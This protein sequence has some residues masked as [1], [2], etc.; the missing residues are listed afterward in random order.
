MSLLVKIC[1]LRS[2]DDVAA[3]VAAGANAVGFVF[4][5]SVRRVTPRQ[6]R[7]ACAGLA[8]DVIRVG[9]MLHPA[10]EEWQDVLDG[11][12]PDVL[13]TDAGDFEKLDVPPSVDRWPVIREGTE[14]GD[15]SLPDTFV[16]EGRKSGVGETVDWD[17]AAERAQRGRMILAGGLDAANVGDAIRIVRPFGVDVSSAVESAPGLK[18]PAKIEHFVQAV[19]AAEKQ[20]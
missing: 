15:G 10:D 4:A 11:F 12:G 2:A 1:G 20:L 9:V 3:A 6:A 7:E 5:D 13:Q 19:R 18:D 16:Y 14:I 8:Q 17:L